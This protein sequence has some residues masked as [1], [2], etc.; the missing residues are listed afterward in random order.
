MGS[1]IKLI[2]SVIF[3]GLKWYYITSL[4]C[5][6]QYCSTLEQVLCKIP[7]QKT[8]G[9]WSGVMFEV[10]A[11]FGIKSLQVLNSSSGYVH[12]TIRKISSLK[13]SILSLITRVVYCLYSE[14]CDQLTIRETRE[15]VQ[16][17]VLVRMT[18]FPLKAIDVR[19]HN[20]NDTSVCTSSCC[21]GSKK[22]K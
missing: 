14:R 20:I 3:I 4:L 11:F 16:M 12:P 10:I 6:L 8:A 7:P 1:P 2:N 13:E 18:D 19:L 17:I 21:Y 22:K 15:K 5:W 9:L